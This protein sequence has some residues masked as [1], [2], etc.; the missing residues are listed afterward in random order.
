MLE[1]NMDL[2]NKFEEAA[3][4]M[5]LR[6]RQK[7]ST[8]VLRNMILE[9][10]IGSFNQCE[11]LNYQELSN[12][13]EKG[14]I[15]GVDG[16]TNNTG[17]PYPYLLTLQQALAKVCNQE[18]G[19]VTITDAFSPLTM[20][21]SMGEEEYREF[22]KENLAC[23]EVKAAIAAFEQYSPRVILLDGSLVR[24]KIE[25][26]PLWEKLKNRALSQNTILVGIVEGISTG[27]I[28]ECLKDRLP[29]SGYPA[30]DWE[31]L[32][33]LLQVGEMLEIAPGLF[34]E[35]FRTCFLRSSVDPKP[36]GIDLPEEQQVYLTEV[37]NLVFTL[38]PRDGRGIPLWLDII[39]KNVR[40]SDTIMEGLLSTYM[41]EEYVEFL[42][43]KRQKRE[44]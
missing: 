44:M 9:K 18:K 22:V 33:G 7:P 20:I 28:S 26:A 10:G 43:P 6:L 36:I 3:K 21:A 15:V 2:K 24:Y 25:A 29:K 35:G 14:G 34:K 41:G 30:S 17:G 39:D 23:L 32:F 13:V 16:S 40:I 38:T 4:A 42:K 27:V 31:I 11:R 37:A 19:H 12:I 1:L 8:Q 5:Q